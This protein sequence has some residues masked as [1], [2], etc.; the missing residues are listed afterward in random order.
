MLFPD[1]G[2]QAAQ[3]R[4][5]L[6]A[7]ALD[8]VQHRPTESFESQLVDRPRVRV[9]LDRQEIQ[10][11]RREPERGFVDVEADHLLVEYSPEDVG[12]RPR[13]I[14]PPAFCDQ[15]PECRQQEHASADGRI[16]NPD[17]LAGIP[18]FERAER[19]SDHQVSDRSGGEVAAFL[20]LLVRRVL[21][22]VE[23]VRLTQD[24]D[25]DVREVQVAPFLLP[26]EKRLAVRRASQHVSQDAINALRQHLEYARRQG[27]QVA[28]ERCIE[29]VR[30]LFRHL[31][32]VEEARRRP[33][34]RPALR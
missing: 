5:L 6:F 31:A 3:R 16:E 26:P 1:A 19:G 27:Q 23:F 11:Q 15:L 9:E 25:R 33:R 20:F 7:F 14:G 8:L 10:T 2:S 34:L 28:V 18:P 12:V 21:P 32:R 22:Q 4:T 17:R 29:P 13:S 30:C 24:T